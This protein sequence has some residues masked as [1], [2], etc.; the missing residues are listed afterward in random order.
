MKVSDM[1]FLKLFCIL[2][3]IEIQAHHIRNRSSQTFKAACAIHSQRRW[4]LTGTPIQNSLDD[5]GALLGFLAIPHLKDKS[6]FD[7]W[8]ATPLKNGRAD[9][10]QRLRDLIRATCLRRTKKT[11][12]S[13]CE[14]PDRTERIE[15]LR[16]HKADQDL[17]SFFKDQCARMAQGISSTKPG[18]P[19]AGRHKEG[20]LL[21]LITL[22]RLICDHGE[23]LLPRSALEAWKAQDGT[24]IDWQTIRRYR[25]R[26]CICE[27]DAN[28][29]ESLDSNGYGS[30]CQH[31]ICTMCALKNES[32][33]E[34]ESSC[35]RC[36]AMPSS[37]WD[38]LRLSSPADVCLPPSA[39][40]EALLRNLHAE[41][42][43]NISQEPSKPVKRFLLLILCNCSFNTCLTITS[44]IF[45]CWTKMPD[46]IQQ[47]LEKQGFHSQR[48]DGKTSLENRKKALNGFNDDPAC[49]VM[50]ASIGSAGEG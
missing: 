39:K 30:H 40:I 48:I 36:A 3:L 4:C 28:E 11:L 41:Q 25:R 46:L 10:L 1:K 35:P 42:A 50:L 20:N 31:W 47:A 5:Y 21:S 12:G 27:I 14:L 24:S 19:E 49:T 16:F 7:F 38:D 44:V 29:A 15:R 13:S 43:I 8:V 2:L 17:Y 6:K 26:C 45:S 23:P 22:L 9:S 34:E 33:S 18:S 37:P 32:A